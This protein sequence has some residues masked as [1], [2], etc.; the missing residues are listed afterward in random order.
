MYSRNIVFLFFLF[1]CI[2]ANAQKGDEFSGELAGWANVVKRFGA[3][4][5]G[6]TDDTKAIQDALDN[7]SVAV[8]GFNTRSASAYSVL[9]LPA[10]KYRISSTLI[11]KGKIGVTI[12]GEN[13]DNTSIIWAGKDGERMFWSNGSAYFR[14][15]RLD[16]NANNRKNITCIALQW[17]DKW[18]TEKSQSFAP[19]NIEISDSYFSGK[20]YYAINGGTY[21]GGDATGANDSEVAIQRCTFRECTFAAIKIEGFNAL[22]YWIW[23]CNFL[24]CKRSIDNSHGNYHV[25][26]CY[27]DQSYDTDIINDNGYYTSVRQSYTYNSN[28]FSHDQGIS[29]NPFKRIF[30]G[31]YVQ[32]MKGNNI[33]FAH[34]GK[35]SLVDNVFTKGFKTK[36]D[37]ALNYGSWCSGI[38]EVLSIGN[39]YGLGE[40]LKIDVSSKIV[41]SIEDARSF[42]GMLKMKEPRFTESQET[43]PVYVKRKIFEVP[44]N[45]GSD[46]IQ[47]I[48]NEA[49]RLRGKRPIVHFAYGEYQLDKTLV[50]P[51]EADLQIIGDGIIYS[52][53]IKKSKNF[54][55]RKPLIIVN[56]PTAITIRDLQLLDHN[57]KESEINA[58]EFT[59]VDQKNG[60]VIIDQLYSSA[61]TAVELNKLDYL[62]VQKQNSFFSAGNNVSGGSMARAG[63]STSGLFCYGG[64]F[65]GLE[66]KNNGKFVAKD[67]WWEG[68]ERTPINLTGSG[69]VTLDGIMVAPVGADS[70]T[71]IDIQK[72]EG[73]V[74]IMNAYVQGGLNVQTDNPDLNLLVWNTHFYHKMAPLQFLDR[75][76]K[77]KGAFMGLS[78][79]CF[80]GSKN[81][82]DILSINDKYPNVK[83]KDAF[84]QEMMVS[85]RAALPRKYQGAFGKTSVLLSRISVGGCETA[86]RFSN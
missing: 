80:D 77:F 24:Q 51:A 72:F 41:H 5:D 52:T 32:G 40:P 60:E 59:N 71:T 75:G 86:I 3:K 84:V 19:V 37:Y 13:P 31:N 39:K 14:V 53:I 82:A 26:R 43:I 11:L 6:K 18:K 61:T 47:K 10:G 22:D 16:W 33:Y 68:A 27:F 1:L 28:C 62:Y 36:G 44:L 15:S 48:I 35:I 79:Q 73:R 78:A 45:S 57:A 54:P 42:Q 85:D 46:A 4:G 25:Y 66:V 9:Y 12:I 21:Q 76:V 70:A 81:C 30:Q 63:K 67:C 50:I 69:D 64:Q 34:L 17:K 83:D 56:G 49:A 38:Y 8:N 58:L 29:C 74:S 7:F 65:A 55:R 23:D 20:P 2:N